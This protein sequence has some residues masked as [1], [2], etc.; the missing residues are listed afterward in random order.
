[1]DIDEP[2]TYADAPFNEGEGDI[3][4][5]TADGVHFCVY[6]VVLALASPFFKAM[7]SLRQPDS[8]AASSSG[9]PVV[10]VSE[11]A[12]ALDCLLRHCYPIQPPTVVD[13]EALGRVLEA[14]IKYDMDQPTRL[15]KARLRD[16][17]ED[18]PLQAYAVSCRLGCEEEA[19]MAAGIWRDQQGWD[20]S[21]E[22]FRHTAAGASFV[23]GAGLSA[24]AYYRLLQCLDG[25]DV[26]S[27]SAPPFV[28]PVTRVTEDSLVQNEDSMAPIYRDTYPFNHPD[29]D[30]VVQ[31]S[32]GINFRVHKLI[33]K[34]YTDKKHT[35]VTLFDNNSDFQ[36]DGLPAIVVPERST[37][38]QDGCN[39]F[40]IS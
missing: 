1:M 31:S 39:S 26:P 20:D 29:D 15:M 9:P 14:A 38:T 33:L 24:G 32:D 19:A 37:V 21:A 8:A 28:P 35:G 12:L 16:L 2:R 17:M 10:P 7:F 25:A 30:F 23:E 34:L 6:R 22:K 11:D 27:F 40:S 4:L 5:R 13:I 18:E 3:I 36:V